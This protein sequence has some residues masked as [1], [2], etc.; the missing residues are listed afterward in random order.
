MASK[1][2]PSSKRRTD[3][4]QN[5]QPAPPLALE[6]QLAAQAMVEQINKLPPEGRPAAQAAAIAAIKAIEATTVAQVE[7]LPGDWPYLQPPRV[8]VEAIGLE[9]MVE[10]LPPSAPAKD[11]AP[12]IELLRTIDESVELPYSVPTF[13]H[14]QT[15]SLIQE[16]T[17][18]MVNYINTHVLG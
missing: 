16:Q 9:M 12:I 5:Q 1:R 6:L 17:N 18:L 3:A 2:T 15:V 14:Y 8:K 10:H 4:N 13:P 11:F 7:A